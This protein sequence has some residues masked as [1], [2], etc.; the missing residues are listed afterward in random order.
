VQPY[1]EVS[2]GAVTRFVFRTPASAPLVVATFFV[3]GFPALYIA[4]G[5]TTFYA[6]LRSA[7]VE[8]ITA[9]LVVVL[10]TLAVVT[11]FWVLFLREAWSSRRVEVDSGQRLVRVRVPGLLRARRTTVAFDSIRR[12]YSDPLGCVRLDVGDHIVDVVDIFHNKDAMGAERLAAR[13]NELVFGVPVSARLRI[14]D[15]HGAEGD[16]ELAAKS[17]A[18]APPESVPAPTR[19]RYER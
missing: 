2:V 19:R 7:G 16:G 14:D 4:A 17:D 8:P 5:A 18:P 3:L 6:Y 12:I 11:P 13:L 1:R 15:V 9:A 10:A